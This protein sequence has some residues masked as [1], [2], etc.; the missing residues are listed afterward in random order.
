MRLALIAMLILATLATNSGRADPLESWEEIENSRDFVKTPELT[1]IQAPAVYLDPKQQARATSYRF[2]DEYQFLFDPVG[3]PLALFDLTLEPVNRKAIS[4]GR[5]ELGS[6]AAR[7]L[8]QKY[9]AGRGDPAELLSGDLSVPGREQETGTFEE[10]AEEGAREFAKLRFGDE[11][12]RRHGREISEGR[13]GFAP[14]SFTLADF[15]LRASQITALAPL[16]SEAF[17]LLYGRAAG[18]VSTREILAQFQM[19]WDEA[20]RSFELK[21]VPRMDQDPVQGGPPPGWI[22]NYARPWD[23]VGYKYML[24][25]IGIRAFEF[26]S[27]LGR[28]SRLFSRILGVAI[29]RLGRSLELRLNWHENRLEAALEA[30]T[31]GGHA[32]RGVP[33][34]DPSRFIELTLTLLDLNKL[35]RPGLRDILD[36]EG[37]HRERLKR[38]AAARKRNVSWL[39]RKGFEVELWPDQRTATLY[40]NSKRKGVLSVVMNPRVLEQGPSLLFYDLAP[41]YGAWYRERLEVFYGASRLSPP[42]GFDFG[43]GILDRDRARALEQLADEGRVAGVCAL[44]LGEVPAI[45]PG[46]SAG[47]LRRIRTTLFR[48]R[49]NDLELPLE[50][51]SEAIQKNLAR[52]QGFLEREVGVNA[53]DWLRYLFL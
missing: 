53:F 44:G 37:K 21:W 25:R 42:R 46:Y 43:S 10:S 33:L 28:S 31:R 16:M 32:L 36:G 22:V 19:S 41:W 35:S 48:Q 24:R 18:N 49:D 15:H 34:R 9:K 50:Q 12:L 11:W 45:I 1:R 14:Q 23:T 7:G 51:E 8:Y 3:R 6:L 27:V 38:E 20:S 30:V 29:S 52:L 17:T 5:V 39:V 40:K 4:L 26:E 2:L 47:E 13:A